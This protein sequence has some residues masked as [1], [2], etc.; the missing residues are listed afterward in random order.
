VSKL[1]YINEK[2]VY[3]SICSQLPAESAGMSQCYIIHRSENM[4]FSQSEIHTHQSFCMQRS[5]DTNCTLAVNN[6]Y[7]IIFTKLLSIKQRLGHFYG[8]C[9]WSVNHGESCMYVNWK[10]SSML[11]FITHVLAALIGKRQSATYTA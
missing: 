1:R 4:C 5:I 6:D 7:M 3:R 2:L 8:E 11:L 9:E 10:A